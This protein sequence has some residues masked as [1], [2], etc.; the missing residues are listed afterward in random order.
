MVFLDPS[1][2]TYLSLDLPTFTPCLPTPSSI[3]VFLLPLL[4]QSPFFFPSFPPRS[5]VSS[6]STYHWS[7]E[8]L[9]DFS[10]LPVPLSLSLLSSIGPSSSIFLSFLSSPPHRP[11]VF[12]CLF[13]NLS[14]SRH[15]SSPLFLV[16]S[17]RSPPLS[18]RPPVRT[19]PP[20]LAQLDPHVDDTV[21]ER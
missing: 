1:T 3:P 17:H 13:S 14:F 20:K 5:F 15:P 10:P 7:F 12:I 6:F 19:L 16:S 8:R 21:V 4:L 18:D 11:S 9:P 2:F